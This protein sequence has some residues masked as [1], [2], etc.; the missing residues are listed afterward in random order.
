MRQATGFERIR[1]RNFTK[2]IT[3]PHKS[4]RLVLPA[5]RR[6][7]KTRRKHA[8]GLPP[9][10]RS[11]GWHCRY[12]AFESGTTEFFDREGTCTWIHESATNLRCRDAPRW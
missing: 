5:I 2:G 10:D 7:M 12:R 1:F 4:Y 11:P 6:P 3:A 8:P 9:A